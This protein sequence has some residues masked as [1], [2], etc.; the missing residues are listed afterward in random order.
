MLLLV[1][2]TRTGKA[3]SAISEDTFATDPMV[4]DAG[5]V[6]GTPIAMPIGHSR[7]WSRESRTGRFCASSSR[8]RPV[9]A[10]GCC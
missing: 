10:T 6:D 4:L 5:K 9:R 7:R 2:L 1:L 3:D 8:V